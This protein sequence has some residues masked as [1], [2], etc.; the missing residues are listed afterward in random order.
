MA[1]VATSYVKINADAE[2]AAK[3]AL[4]YLQYRAGYEGE[5]IAR[6]LFGIDGSME[7]HEFYHMID[8]A[9]EKS[10]FFRFILSPDPIGEDSQR[11][12][13]L[14]ETTQLMVMALE[15]K[16]QKP[17][18]WVAAIHDDH[19]DKRHVHVLAIVPQRLQVPH[20]QLL[21]TAATHACLEERQEL[22]LY[23]RSRER[24]LERE[25]AA[26]VLSL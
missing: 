7:R 21:T 26:W 25:E 13:P 12:L 14:R 1:V 17:I 23:A 20:L 5:R 11:D 9:P 10:I 6:P 16:I 2:K 4:R 19:T 22:D 24:E 18:P 8:Q 15:D 3:A